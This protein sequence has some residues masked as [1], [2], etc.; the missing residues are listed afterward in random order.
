MHVWKWHFNFFLYF[1]LHIWTKTS[2]IAIYQFLL[3][4]PAS[5]L[6]PSPAQQQQQQQQQQPFSVR[7]EIART[8]VGDMGAHNVFLET[9]ELGEEVRVRFEDFLEGFL[10]VDED[11]DE[12][13]EVAQTS[14]LPTY[15][16]QLESMVEREGQT[17]FL[18]LADVEAYDS[19]LNEAVICEFYRYEPFLLLGVRGVVEKRFPE[20]L[21]GGGTDQ[22]GKKALFLSCYN[23]PSGLIE[24]RDLKTAAL[25]RLTSVRGTV[26]RTSDVRPELLSGNF[27]CGK[28]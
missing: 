8:D 19:E 5:P 18:D 17:L 15:V 11:E 2:H 14:V 6:P 9:D 27:R 28:W 12:D 7:D 1:F 13:A 20:Y 3:M 21:G 16:D 10:R 24:I 25:S 26:T 23:L 22:S 4:E